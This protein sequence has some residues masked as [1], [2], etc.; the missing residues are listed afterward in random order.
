MFQRKDK[1]ESIRALF[2]AP[3]G[4]NDVAFV[5]LGNSGVILRTRQGT[6][7]FDVADLL[8]A[9]DARALEGLD[10]L[11]YTHDHTDHYSSREA[12]EILKVTDARIVAE[13]S[14][15]RDLRG[16]V[17]SERLTS[18]EPSKTY[19][20]GDFEIKTIRG[21]HLGPI[22]LYRVGVG[23]IS[24]FHGGDSGYVP[25]KEYPSGLAF[26]PTG[27]PS[28]TA[29]PGDAVKMAV[30]LKSKTAVAIH[31]SASQNRAFEKGVKDRVPGISAIIPE[32][33]KAEK[34]TL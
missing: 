4:M 26:L 20:V 17:P 34:V 1:A 10:I 13:P 32:P 5:Y 15:A 9:E 30:D 2:S 33:Y 25:V 24:I 22:I 8:R 23:E 19:G 18:A 14:V 11:L 29:S 28:P 27:G 31:G 21:V 7:A 16:K 6:I 3:L 12:I